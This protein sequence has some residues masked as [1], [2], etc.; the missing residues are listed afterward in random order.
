M[1]T[2]PKVSPAMLD[3]LLWFY[4]TGNWDH[5]RVGTSAALVERK[6]VGHS[7]RGIKPDQI[8]DDGVAVL[9]AEG[10]LTH[11]V[12]DTVRER[13]AEGL[14]GT[15]TEVHPNHI[16]TTVGAGGC[17]AYLPVSKF[18]AVWARTH[19]DDHGADL[20]ADVAQLA[21]SGDD[22]HTTP[23]FVPE[24]YMDDLSLIINLDLDARNPRRR[25]AEL[26]LQVPA[27]YRFKL[28][29]V[30]A[31]DYLGDSDQI[32][33]SL[34]RLVARH[35]QWRPVPV[36]ARYI[37]CQIGQSEQWGVL[38]RSHPLDTG[39]PVWAA[40]ANHSELRWDSFDGAAAEARR[41]N[42]T[43]PGAT[44]HT[45]GDAVVQTPYKGSE[46]HIGDVISGRCVTYNS[47][48][49]GTV[50]CVI[51]PIKSP[52]CGGYRYRIRSED[53]RTYTVFAERFA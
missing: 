8:T 10:R 29:T 35:E 42:A 9:L 3:A 11:E 31:R 26:L 1:R 27:P 38:D 15:V 25:R 37:P 50:V 40:D 48:R 28:S 36:L 53:G 43:V 47:E 16:V 41:L 33:S 7:R 14:V 23:G 4:E 24:G 17:A 20:A 12:G 2:L 46:V 21:D 51:G 13:R 18:P 39:T 22:D 5:I 49:T 30:A 19:E 45:A 52:D 34:G 6:L 32:V 44:L